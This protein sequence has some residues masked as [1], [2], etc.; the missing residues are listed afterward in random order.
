MKTRK[1]I[2]RYAVLCLASIAMCVGLTAC[3]TDSAAN[4]SPDAA[5]TEAQQPPANGDQQGG[6]PPGRGGER[7]LG[8]DMMDLS[9]LVAAGTI[10]QETADKISEFMQNQTPPQQNNTDSAQTE[11][12]DPFAEMVKEGIITQEQS[13]AIRA[14]SAPEPPADERPVRTN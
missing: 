7:G 12:T 10:N 9:S 14:A 4:N 6:Q 11:R 2:K 5:T 3:G 8:T 1:S 13:E